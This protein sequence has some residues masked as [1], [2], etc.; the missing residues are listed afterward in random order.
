MFIGQS[1]LIYKSTYSY[2]YYLGCFGEQG[3]EKCDSTG[4]ANKE[5]IFLY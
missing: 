1:Y 3:T 5:F 4:F 2:L